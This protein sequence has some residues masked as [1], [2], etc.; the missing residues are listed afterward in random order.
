M[1]PDFTG[2]ILAGGQSQR[3]GSDKALFE[4]DGTPMIQ[5]Q[6]DTLSALIHPVF[7][8]T[9]ASKRTYDIPA[10]QLVDL[11]PGAGPLAGLH[12]GLLASNTAWL[13]VLAADMPFI[14][15]ETLEWIIMQCDT[16]LDVVVAKSNDRLQPLCGCFRAATIEQVEKRLNHGE[17]AVMGLLDVLTVKTVDVPYLQLRNINHLKDLE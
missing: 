8:S 2:L 1:I 13:F 5:R 16:A 17:Y 10:K 11:F 15:I 4:I 9:G 3:F 7:I 14:T 12:A 6:F